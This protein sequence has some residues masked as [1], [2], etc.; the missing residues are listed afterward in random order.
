MFPNY[1]CVGAAKTTLMFDDSLEGF[2]EHR[3]VVR[4]SG[5]Y[6]ERILIKTSKG[7]SVS[8]TQ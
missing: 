4:A 2:T 1:R 7:E 8:L 6:R 3:Q 5:Y